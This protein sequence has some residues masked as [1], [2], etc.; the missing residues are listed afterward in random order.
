LRDGNNALNKDSELITKAS[1][2]LKRLPLCDK[3]EVLAF[4]YLKRQL[5]EE[6]GEYKE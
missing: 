5:A 4:I 1:S 6:H 3:E 2:I